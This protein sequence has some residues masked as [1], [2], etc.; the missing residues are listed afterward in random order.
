MV[1]GFLAHDFDIG[2][3][4]P[5]RRVAEKYDCHCNKLNPTYWALEE[6]YCIWSLGIKD[7]QYVHRYF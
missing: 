3:K 5:F 7:L 1:E 6:N 4:H 2:E